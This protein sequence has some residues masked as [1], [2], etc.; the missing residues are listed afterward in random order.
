[1]PGGYGG[2]DI[3]KTKYNDNTK[4]WSEWQ[5]LGGF[6]NTAG[7]EISISISND[8]NTFYISSDGH[9]G[10]G[11]YD[12]FRVDKDS[13][14]EWRNEIV[15]LGTPIN[16][17]LNDIYYSSIGEISDYAYY[18]SQRDNISSKI[19]D[20]YSVN[21]KKPILFE[22]KRTDSTVEAE[23]LKQ[24]ML[25]EVLA[26]AATRERVFKAAAKAR[27]DSLQLIIK[28]CEQALR[29]EIQ[30]RHGEQTIA[31]REQS[32]KDIA[33]TDRDSSQ[34]G[35]EESK[36]IL[37]EAA[38]RTREDNLL[39][40]CGYTD[41]ETITVPKYGDRI[42]LKN[43]LFEKDKSTL[44]KNSFSE[45][46]RL[47]NFMQRFPDIKVEIGGHTSS[48]GSY[49]INQKLSEARAKTV[50]DYLV[51]KGVDASRLQTHGYSYSVPIEDENTEFGKMF[52]RRVEI[53]IIK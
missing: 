19:Y 8:E 48:E 21:Y 49:E 10:V 16:T 13:N 11:G 18:S 36:Q 37:S 40:K 32:F 25:E 44:R 26:E 34:R 17:P 12:I 43:I 39:T 30:T 53:I 41:M 51:R 50:K 24:S 22:Y 20:I 3:W 14:G 52:N 9:G 15:N 29:N 31:A 2:F 6:I 47:Y 35:V 23:C 1:M 38:T 27:E 7:N 5:N 42:Y 4:K 45:L 33:K 46:N 28:E